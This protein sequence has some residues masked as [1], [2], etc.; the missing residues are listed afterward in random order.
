MSE[1]GFVKIASVG[2][3]TEAEQ[4]VCILKENGILA[5]RQG[6]IM[7]LYM[8]DSYAG[9]D[10]MVAET[11]EEPAKKLLESFPQIQT[12]MTCHKRELSRTQRI[13]GWVLLIIMVL[14]IVVPV[15]LL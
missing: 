2:S 4:M 1:N 5:W 10:I 9:E 13:L 14:C 15:I 6:S 12:K 8:G 11:D 7:D 3:M